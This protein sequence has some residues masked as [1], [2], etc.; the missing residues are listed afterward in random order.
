M[1][2]GPINWSTYMLLYYSLLYS[3]YLLI[4]D[5]SQI[6]SSHIPINFTL[7]TCVCRVFNRVQV[8]L[9]VFLPARVQVWLRFHTR[10]RV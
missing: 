1:Y 5:D 9:W 2:V 6:L 7:L 3:F 10:M 4:F 8:T